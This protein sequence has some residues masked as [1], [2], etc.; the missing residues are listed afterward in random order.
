MIKLPPSIHKF[1]YTRQEVLDI[2]RPLK[3][4]HKR[5]WKEFGV[6]TVSVHPKTGESL[7]Y[8]VDIITAIRCCQ[9]NRDK[10]LYEWD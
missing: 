10:N 8:G 9:G 3:I 2:I 7:L 5:F 6:N 1:G 4:H